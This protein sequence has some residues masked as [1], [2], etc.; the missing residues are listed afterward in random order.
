M[1]ASTGRDLIV[2]LWNVETFELMRT[3]GGLTAEVWLADFTV[4]VGAA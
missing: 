2:N 3:I 4:S 1:L